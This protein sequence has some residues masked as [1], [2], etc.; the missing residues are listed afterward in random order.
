MVLNITP[1]Q[2]SSLIT[3]L[4]F[5]VNE[6]IADSTETAHAIRQALNIALAE[7]DGELRLWQKRQIRSK[8]VALGVYTWLDITGMSDEYLEETYERFRFLLEV[9][10]PK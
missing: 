4:S 10:W 8:L 2:K 3:Y 6:T 9:S 1:K 5:A 7:K